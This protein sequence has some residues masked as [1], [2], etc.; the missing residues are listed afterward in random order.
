MR[1]APA[2]QTQ[3]E[4]M[5]RAARAKNDAAASQVTISSSTLRLCAAKRSHTCATASN[6]AAMR[7]LWAR[8]SAV[9]GS[10]MGGMLANDPAYAHG[11]RTREP[12]PS[13]WGNPASESGFAN[14]KPSP[15][16]ARAALASPRQRPAAAADALP[17]ALLC[18]RANSARRFRVGPAQAACP[19]SPEDRELEQAS[20]RK[21]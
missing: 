20:R 16:V 1:A 14:V 5:R 15:C 12:P 10:R 8:A 4:S 2:T 6:T 19:S 7:S 3:I 9:R 17:T 18:H 11:A 13:Y 21:V